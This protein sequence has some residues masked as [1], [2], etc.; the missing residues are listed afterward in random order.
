MK[1]I[2]PNLLVILAIVIISGGYFIK[3][4]QGKVI[5]QGDIVQW[6]SIASEILTSKEKEPLLWA[7]NMFGGMPVYQTSLPAKNNYVTVL[8]NFLTLRIGPPAG[9]FIMAMMSF[10]IM[11]LMMGIRPWVSLIGAI[12]FAFATGNVVLYEAGHNTKLQTVFCFPLIVGGLYSIMNKKYLLGGAVFAAGLSL[13]LA[14]NHPQMTY[15]FFL[16]LLILAIIHLVESVMN[17]EMLH[18]GKAIGV[19]LVGV[20]LSLGSSATNLMTTFEYQEETMRG[21]P[22][23][24][25]AIAKDNLGTP[26][27]SSKGGLDYDYAMSWSNTSVDLLSSFIPMSAGGASTQWLDKNSLLAKKVGQNN[28]FQAPTYWGGLPFTSGPY[29]LGIFSCFLFVFGMFILKGRFRWWIFASVLFTLALSLGRHFASFNDIFFNYFPL[30]NKF[31]T[32]NS[33]LTISCLFMPI[34]G[35]L[36][37]DEI[38]NTSKEDRTKFIKPLFMSA[39]IVGG[40][41]A[42]VA[43]MGGSLFDFSHGESDQQYANILDVL[44]EQRSS[45]LS[46]SAWKNVFLVILGAGGIWAFLKG[47]LNQYILVGLCSLIM[48]FDLVPVAKMYLSDKDFIRPSTLTQAKEERPVDAQIKA[49]PDPH[50]R[51]YDATIDPFNDASASRHHKTIGGYHPA[52]LKRYQDLIERHIGKGNQSVLNMMNT[53]Y[54]ILSNG[55]GQPPRVQINPQAFGNAWFV[56]T[57]KMVSSANAE[58]DSLNAVTQDFAVVN[59]EFKNYVKDLTLNKAGTIKLSKISNNLFEYDTESN[60]EQL[61]LFSEVYYGPNKGW[62]AYIDDKPADF[63]RAN[64]LLRALKVPQGN[65]KVKFEFKP[66][67]FYTGEK[68]SLI[69]SL[70]ILFGFLA[71]IGLGIRK[72]LAL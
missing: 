20:I 29:Y 53:K 39:G 18:L 66:A 70:I 49:D 47:F 3:Q 69:C 13:A 24:E 41:C 11:A 14:N 34:L 26:Q 19:L 4:F 36:A 68:I 35:C 44:L 22:T 5:K 2:I 45:M 9:F 57:I 72:S 10:F 52:K 48:L 42:I 63:I 55:E 31:R 54:F 65:H 27:K 60:S 28:D 71:V 62:N 33:V 37:I 17:G 59:D 43:L 38:L 7:N 8:Q 1:K 25:A 64:Y 30:F 16:T 58:I 12:G 6:E 46:S 15:Y 50:Y 21:K 56:D 32:P 51:V 67:S 40:F 61:A 23:L